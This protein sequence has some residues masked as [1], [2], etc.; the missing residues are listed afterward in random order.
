MTQVPASYVVTKTL[1][2]SNALTVFKQA[3][4]TCGNQTV[5]HFDLCLDD[6][7]EHVFLEKEGQ[8]QKQYMQRNILL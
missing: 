7:A 4:I 2:K 6:M 1:L 8:I 5:P 3:E